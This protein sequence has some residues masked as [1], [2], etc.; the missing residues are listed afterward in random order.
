MSL[1]T[2]LCRHLSTAVDAGVPQ[3]LEPANG[4]QCSRDM[5][6]GLYYITKER[7]QRSS[8]GRHGVLLSRGSALPTKRPPDLHAAIKMLRGHIQRLIRLAD[9]CSTRHVTEAGYINELLTKKSLQ[10]SR[11]RRTNCTAQFLTTQGA[12]P[13]WRSRAGFNLNDVIIPPKNIGRQG[14][15]AAG[16]EL[17]HGSTNNER[18]NQ[19][20]TGRT[21][22]FRLDGAFETR[23]SRI[24]LH[25]RDDALG[26][27]SRSR[28]VSSL[29][30]VA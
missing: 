23:P 27:W 4:A 13:R 7:K 11:T 16:G 2:R 8:S 26:A 12:W 22:F 6:L 30:C 18:Y 21:Q 14:D 20:L 15:P 29:A 1:A 17:Q 25:L 10:V 24:Q 9:G 19:I 5:V 28:F 3:H